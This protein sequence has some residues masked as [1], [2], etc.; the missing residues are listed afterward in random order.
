MENSLIM[1]KD[2]KCTTNSTPGKNHHEW[3]E[4]NGE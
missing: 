3:I 4:K 2:K 1:D